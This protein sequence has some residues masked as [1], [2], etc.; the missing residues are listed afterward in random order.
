[1]SALFISLSVL[2]LLFLQEETVLSQLFMTGRSHYS[3]YEK[4]SLLHNLQNP[5]ELSLV[6]G[7]VRAVLLVYYNNLFE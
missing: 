1:M 4:E 2:S 7:R 3:L 6:E 5:W